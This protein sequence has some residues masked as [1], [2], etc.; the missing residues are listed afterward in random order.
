MTVGNQPSKSNAQRAASLAWPMLSLAS[1][2][3]SLWLLQVKL[4]A[5][6]SSDPAVRAALDDGA[7]WGDLK[8]VSLAVGE[9]LMLIPVEGYALAGLA[10]LVAYAALAWYDR[11]AL[12][13]LG[14][15]SGISWG[16][17]GVSS[18]VAYA[19]GH[20]MGASVFSGG[21]VRLRAYT[22]KG[23][24][25]TEVAVLVG[26][27]TFTF[28]YGTALLL[29]YVL[30]TEPQIVDPLGGI[31]P[32]LALP[33][34]LI[35]VIGATLLALCL[36]YVIGSLCRFKPF[37][38]GAHSLIYPK[39]TVV[40]RQLIAAP[41]ELIA[42]AAIIYFALPASGNPGFFMVL[43]AFLISFS[44]GLLSQVPGGIGVMEAVFLA[45]MPEMPVTSVV[46]A[47]LVWRL[48]YLLIPLA[49]SGPIILA[50]EHSRLG[51]AV[52]GRGSR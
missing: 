11:I 33:T 7:F 40:V 45:V 42:A 36:L 22:A 34:W 43:G 13:H 5:E 10:T 51:R 27:C 18:F 44:A 49:L 6:V 8:V 14:R 1:V 26:M 3:W 41:L 9:R 46:A 25:K 16:Y 32:F 23:L 12:I 4:E 31:V 39:F 38:V 47:L 17:V 19:L 21:L 29:G 20:N 52:G 2:V 35:R 24:T 48:L 15:T 50:F 30:L 28:V 37:R